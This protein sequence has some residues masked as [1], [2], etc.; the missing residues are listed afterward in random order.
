MTFLFTHSPHAFILSRL[1]SLLTTAHGYPSEVRHYDALPLI[2]QTATSAFMRLHELCRDR[3]PKGAP[4]NQ[5]ENTLFGVVLPTNTRSNQ[6]RQ[7]RV[8]DTR[9]GSHINDNTCTEITM[10]PLSPGTHMSHGTGTVLEAPAT[11]ALS[12]N[13][14]KAFVGVQAELRP[15]LMTTLSG[16]R[17]DV[18][19]KDQQR[20]NGSFREVLTAFYCQPLED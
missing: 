6:R 19:R 17:Y 15:R 5:H 10:F 8:G 16:S 14:V 4:A 1:C 13:D 12:N 11:T 7:V 20:V 18:H 9:F 2:L 3:P